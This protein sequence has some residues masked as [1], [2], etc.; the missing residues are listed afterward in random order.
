MTA[1]L[2]N[3][4]AGPNRALGD[5]AKLRETESIVHRGRNERSQWPTSRITD[6]NVTCNGD[7]RLETVATSDNETA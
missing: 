2:E 4:A 5:L 6:S 7:S 3:Y 1:E